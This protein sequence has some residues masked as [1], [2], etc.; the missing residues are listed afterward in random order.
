MLAAEM[1]A[2]AGPKQGGRFQKGQSGNPAG[3]PKGARHKTTMMVE[4]L[5]EGQAESITQTAIR[6]AIEGD[7]VA[8]R[9]CLERLISPRRDRPVS[10]KLPKVESA[11]DCSA[12]MSSLLGAVANGD[13]SPGEATD[14]AKLIEV[15]TRVLETTE[16]E[17]RLKS[18][19]ER[20]G[21]EVR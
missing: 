19:E 13:M 16:I 17:S 12:L 4:A 2:N 11:E 8:M 21:G 9:L 5:L 14:V 1:T 18:L 6:K 15:H 3:K 10:F 20:F 7:P